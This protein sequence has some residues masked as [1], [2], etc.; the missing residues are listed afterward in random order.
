MADS[1]ESWI[2]RTSPVYD[3]EASGTSFELTYSNTIVFVYG[4][5]HKAFEHIHV[6]PVGEDED[7]YARIFDCPD[8]IQELRD[9]HFPT[10]VLPY[11][12]VAVELSRW[13]LDHAETELDF[14]INEDGIPPEFFEGEPG[15]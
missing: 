15:V 2:T 14:E 5:L 1:F 12:D 4:S 10:A 7:E 11:P 8:E 6:S 3:L 13:K 9:L